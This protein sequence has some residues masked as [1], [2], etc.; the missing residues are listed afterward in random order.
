MLHRSGLLAQSV[1]NRLP[2]VAQEIIPPLKVGM[3][4][5]LS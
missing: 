1:K 2:F 3:I 4:L 5:T